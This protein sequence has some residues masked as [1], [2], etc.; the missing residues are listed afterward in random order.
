MALLD[1]TL[2]GGCIPVAELAAVTLLCSLAYL[3]QAEID[4]Q[5]KYNERGDLIQS[6]GP[7]WKG[8]SQGPTF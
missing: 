3:A 4:H 2:I 1:R 5:G 7:A 6:E 8:D